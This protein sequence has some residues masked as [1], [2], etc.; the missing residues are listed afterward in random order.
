MTMHAFFDPLGAFAADT[1]RAKRLR[2][3]AA[4]AVGELFHHDGVFRAVE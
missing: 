3:R 2:V 1:R 4:F